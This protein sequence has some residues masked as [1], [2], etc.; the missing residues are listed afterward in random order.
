MVYLCISTIDA[1]SAPQLARQ[2]VEE[3]LAACV[4]IIPGARSIYRWEGKLCDETE[5]VLF[6]K[7]APRTL[8]GFEERFRDLH[9]YD[10]PELLVIPI[11]DGLKEYMSWV[12]EMTR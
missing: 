9:P 6:I 3:G 5:S 10:C 1:A 12:T 2:L 8:G 7:T 11:E 4:N